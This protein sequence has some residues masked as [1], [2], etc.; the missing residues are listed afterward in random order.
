MAALSIE[1]YA[2]VTPADYIVLFTGSGRVRALRRED[3]HAIRAAL[4]DPDGAVLLDVGTGRTFR[5]GSSRRGSL[6]EARW[7]EPD[8][9]LNRAIVSR[10]CEK[11]CDCECL[12]SEWLL[13]RF[14][15]IVICGGT[16]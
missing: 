11:L 15:C 13:S 12:G 3:G 4:A 14:G 10:L 9:R 7:H 5:I 16:A 2:A 8:I 1:Y 6:R